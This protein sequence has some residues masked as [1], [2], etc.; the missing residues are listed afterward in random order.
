MYVAVFIICLASPV[1]APISWEKWHH[2]WGKVSE[3]EDVDELDGLTQHF[4]IHY[5]LV[6]FSYT[7]GGLARVCICVSSLVHVI[8]SSSDEMKM[9][10]P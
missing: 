9:P 4:L 7:Q 10:E 2:P 6:I 1:A 8:S 5:S 3:K